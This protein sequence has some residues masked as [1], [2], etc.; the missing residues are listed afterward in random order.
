[1]N[2][3]GWDLLSLVHGTNN[4]TIFAEQVRSEN[5]L[6]HQIIILGLSRV[7]VIESF[8]I[9]D[10]NIFIVLTPTDKGNESH[11]RIQIGL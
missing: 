5:C 3:D 7:C 9:N 2:L 1:M 4:T 6:F 11:T 10:F 8:P